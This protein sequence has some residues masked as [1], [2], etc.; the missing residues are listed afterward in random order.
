[1]GP[2]QRRRDVE[3]APRERE[4]RSR[5]QEPP[6][7]Q[8]DLHDPTDQGGPRRRRDLLPLVG[9]RLGPGPRRSGPGRR[10]Q[11]ED[12]RGGH[13]PGLERAPSR[14][15]GILPYQE[16]RRSG[17][18]DHRYRI[19]VAEP[20]QVREGVRRRDRRRMPGRDDRVRPRGVRRRKQYVRRPAV[21]T[22]PRRPH[23]RHEDLR[24]VRVGSADP[25]GA[26]PVV[27][28][29]RGVSVVGLLPEQPALGVRRDDPPEP[30][31]RRRV[32]PGLRPPELL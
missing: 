9:D 28:I 21:R 22:V 29:D 12:L 4:R 15:R 24:S 1:M 32:P 3:V 8:R 5:S 7:R 26:P 13:R 17:R 23:A 30:D 19:V 20:A 2:I 31:A 25:A 27:E 10:R 16:W 11:L 6:L 14:A 18:S